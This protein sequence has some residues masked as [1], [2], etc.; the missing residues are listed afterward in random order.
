MSMDELTDLLED[1]FEEL[2]RYTNRCW[3]T[4]G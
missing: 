3:L 1:R 4:V 2:E